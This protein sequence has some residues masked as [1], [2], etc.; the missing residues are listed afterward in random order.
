MAEEAVVDSVEITPAEVAEA[1]ALGWAEKEAWRG[2]PEDHLDARAFL[3]RGRHLLPV[4]QENNRRLLSDLNSVKSEVGG[5]KEA[6]QAAQAVIKTLEA[7]HDEDVQAQVAAAR[8][9]LK[10]E[11]AAASEAGDHKGIA[12]ITDKLTQL[13][14]AESKAEVREEKNRRASDRANGGTQQITGPHAAEVQ[15]WFKD[16]PQYT[17]DARRIALGNAITIELREKGNMKM[18]A[19]FCDEVA[20]EVE[21]ALGGGDAGG[22]VNRVAGGGPSD[23]TN[24]SRKTYADLP[25][26]VKAICDRQGTKVIGPGRAHKDAASWRASYV[27]QYFS[28]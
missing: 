28:E 15:Q 12:D 26:E 17:T 1:K 20:A 25:A 14:T 23:R 27:R 8:A 19:A 10:E 2:K 4:M 16:H 7:S 5:L 6:L 3:E 21:R 22:G 11:L 24:S 13:G 18:G 9:A